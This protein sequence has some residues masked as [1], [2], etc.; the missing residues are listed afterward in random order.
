MH[1]EK[2]VDEDVYSNFRNDVLRD[3]KVLQRFIDTSMYRKVPF[4]ESFGPIRSLETGLQQLAQYVRYDQISCSS[5]QSEILK[6]L[7]FHKFN[8]SSQLQKAR[9]FCVPLIRAGFTD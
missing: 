3:R 6:H 5:D 8:Q 9:R 2:R 1:L 4:H 7:L